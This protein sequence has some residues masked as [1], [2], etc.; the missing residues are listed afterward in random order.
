MKIFI[1]DRGTIEKYKLG[2]R[3]LVYMLKQGTSSDTLLISE[4]IFNSVI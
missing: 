4:N 2:K 1:V 3:T